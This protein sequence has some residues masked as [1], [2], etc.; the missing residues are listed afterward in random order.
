MVRILFSFL[1][2]SGLSSLAR[3]EISWVRENHELTLKDGTQLQI[4]LKKPAQSSP[5]SLPAILLFGGFQT[6]AKALELVD[7]AKPV[8]LVTFEYPLRIPPRFSIWKNLGIIPQ[9]KKAMHDTVD[10]VHALIDWLQTQGD[11]NPDKIILAAASF[12]A[13][14]VSI[15]AGDNPKVRGIILVHG[16]ANVSETAAFLIE[17]SWS[18]S[19]G[20][21]AHGPAVLA[22]KMLWWYV[23]LP[24][25]AEKLAQLQ[26]HQRVLLFT[27]TQDDYLP[28]QTH[29]HL[30]ESLRKSRAS[31]EERKL[32]T[33]HIQPN[34]I[35][36]IEKIVNES[37]KWSEGISP[38][39]P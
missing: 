3:A 18:K 29:E 34:R 35:D 15:V 14:F 1:I 19:I 16:F 31:W 39:R 9:A 26:E 7:P 33:T 13:P 4:F 38:R 30:R 37:L 28:P 20:F 24:S 27:A 36:L 12:G 11:V 23:E 10:G 6:G 8:L 17:R 2:F 5:R 32:N 22:A 25:P 21:W